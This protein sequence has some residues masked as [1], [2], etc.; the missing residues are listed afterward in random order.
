MR[1]VLLGLV[2]VTGCSGHGTSP[3]LT[4]TEPDAAIVDHSDPCAS[5]IGTAVITAAHQNLE[6]QY[7]RV[8]AG[9]IFTGGGDS[10]STTLGF[11]LNLYFTNEELET[12]QAILE[13]Q[14]GSTET[15]SQVG[16]RVDTDFERSAELGDH[17]ATIRDYGST[18]QATGTVTLTDLVYPD[19]VAGHVAGS[20]HV[21]ST[22]PQV[23]IDGTFDN[24]FCSGL[25]EAAL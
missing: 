13:C 15:C 21:E 12:S 14:N 1:V 10:G 17:T 3:P 19:Q 25:L 20:I 18:W 22:S 2:A 8:Y 16:F 9:G 5:A 6:S 7:G 11:G 24:A 4:A 23:T